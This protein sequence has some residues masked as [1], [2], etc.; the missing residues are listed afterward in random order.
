MRSCL[1]AT[2]CIVRFSRETAGSRLLGAEAN[3]FQA[4]SALM[5]TNVGSQ[6]RKCQAPAILFRPVQIA[7]EVSP[8]GAASVANIFVGWPRIVT[9]CQPFLHC[10]GNDRKSRFHAKTHDRAQGLQPSSYRPERRSCPVVEANALP[11]STP[12]V[13]KSV[14]IA[15]RPCPEPFSAAAM[16]QDY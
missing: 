1:G 2:H 10:F 8:F 13:K 9:A 15:C 12:P 3:A 14:S 16:P 6:S 11:N 7:T 5:R 4:T